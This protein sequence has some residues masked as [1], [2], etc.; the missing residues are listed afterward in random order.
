MTIEYDLRFLIGILLG[1]I[2]AIRQLGGRPK[3][4]VR[5]AE[6]VKDLSLPGRIHNDFGIHPPSY[7]M[8]NR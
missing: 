8:E 2:L 4:G 3:D 1:A 6:G 7:S 5:F